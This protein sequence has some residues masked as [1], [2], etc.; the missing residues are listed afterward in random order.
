[1]KLDKLFQSLLLTGAV[2]VFISAPARSEEVREDTQAKSST[3]TTG[4][5]TSNDTVAVTDQEFV[6]SK[7][8]L[9]APSNRTTRHFPSIVANSLRKAKAKNI[10]Q[11]NE[12]EPFPKVQNYLYSR[13]PQK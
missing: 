1:M 10:P 8:P 2:I 12:V 9:L 13:Q 3:A 11:L 5:S 7:S 4:K 6:S